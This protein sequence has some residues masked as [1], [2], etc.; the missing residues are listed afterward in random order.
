[1]YW[2]DFGRNDVYVGTGGRFRRQDMKTVSGEEKACITAFFS[3]HLLK[4]Y[5]ENT[6]SYDNSD[7]ER[8]TDSSSSSS[9]YVYREVNTE[10]DLYGVVMQGDE[11][12][13]IVFY[14]KDGRDVTCK[15]FNFNGVP[16]A[17]MMLGYSA[18]HSSSYQTV[19]RVMLVKRVKTVPP[20]KHARQTLSRAKCSPKSKR[21]PKASRKLN[22]KAN[23][24]GYLACEIAPFLFFAC[25]LGSVLWK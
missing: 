17:Y 23:E 3:E 12:T 4:I 6:R 24:K 22:P 18:S 16:E 8:V 10:R 15:V 13:G 5:E 21:V 14:I 1:M 2:Y 20:P 11:I 9:N 19:G 7:D 25:F